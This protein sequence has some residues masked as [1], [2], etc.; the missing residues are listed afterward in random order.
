MNM[1]GFLSIQTKLGVRLHNRISLHVPVVGIGQ[2]LNPRQ[3]AM[4]Q[5]AGYQAGLV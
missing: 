4:I 1:R 3:S 2:M 5:D